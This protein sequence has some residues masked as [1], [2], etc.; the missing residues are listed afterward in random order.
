[1]SLDV[2]RIRDG[3]CVGGLIAL[4]LLS[5]WGFYLLAKAGL[6]WFLRQRSQS[7]PGAGR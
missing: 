3:F 7:S 6:R 5:V 2:G 1:V 4:L